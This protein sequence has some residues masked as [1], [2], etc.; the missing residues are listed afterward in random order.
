MFMEGTIEEFECAFNDMLEMFNL[1]VHKWVID[2][3]MLS[4]L[5]GQRL[6]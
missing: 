1:H 6:I 3:Y 5:D 2:I 4:V